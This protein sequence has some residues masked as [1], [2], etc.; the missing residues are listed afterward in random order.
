MNRKQKQLKKHYEYL[1]QS[2]IANDKFLLFYEYDTH[3]KQLTLKEKELIS[4]LI[5]A[6]KTKEITMKTTVEM[7]NDFPCLSNILIQEQIDYFKDVDKVM[8]KSYISMFKTLN[9][10]GLE[11]LF[12]RFNI[13]S[14]GI[15][16][17]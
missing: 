17:H 8:T 9:K 5:W 2:K 10:K 14:G 15:G 1:L 6:K 11:Y 3:G 12:Q 7:I 16:I 4:D 13:Q